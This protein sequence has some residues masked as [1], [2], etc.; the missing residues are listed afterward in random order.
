MMADAQSNPLSTVSARKSDEMTVQKIEK[1]C[2][3][4]FFIMMYSPC[5]VF[6]KNCMCRMLSLCHR[7]SLVHYTTDSWMIQIFRAML[8]NE[9]LC[10]I[11]KCQFFSIS[12]KQKYIF[13]KENRY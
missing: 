11:D 4:I 10:I 6:G 3:D 13:Q 1:M 7:L 12:V 9:G 2:G 8:A 5:F